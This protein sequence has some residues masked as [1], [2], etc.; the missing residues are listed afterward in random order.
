MFLP[1]TSKEIATAKRGVIV[2]VDLGFSKASKSTGI[3]T[4]SPGKKVLVEKQTFANS[5]ESVAKLF[6]EAS[7]NTLILEAPLSSQFNFDGNPSPRQFE[8]RKD[9]ASGKVKSRAWYIHAGA[10][11]LLAA[12][13]F[14]RRLR[15]KL[16]DSFEGNIF[17]YEGFHTF[18]H[19]STD[20]GRDAQEILTSFIENGVADIDAGVATSWV[21]V[22]QVLGFGEGNMP[23]VVL[24]NPKRAEMG[25][26]H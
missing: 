9:L 14:L 2:A 16:N 5:I 18:K 25:E 7:P 23:S 6:I 13:F 17:V 3:A 4:L 8:T 12:M 19:A 20:H 11:T 26:A 22:L 10:A 15:K 24:I 1:G 21:S